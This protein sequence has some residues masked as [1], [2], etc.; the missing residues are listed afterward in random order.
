MAATAKTAERGR[1]MKI[2]GLPS[3][4]I[5]DCR[6]ALSIMG[7]R[8]RAKTSGAGSYSNFYIRYPTTP[9]DAMT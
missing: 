6:N 8:T 5:R 4:M 7:A 1:V 2:K 3:E 9:K